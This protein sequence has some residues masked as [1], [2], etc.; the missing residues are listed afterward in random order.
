MAITIEQR[1]EIVSTA[2]KAIFYLEEIKKETEKD[3]PNPESLES[4]QESASV[5][6]GKLTALI[7]EL[8]S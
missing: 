4:Y 7:S 1:A 8:E 3:N 2:E 6:S 5:E